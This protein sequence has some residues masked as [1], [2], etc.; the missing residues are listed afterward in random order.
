VF[1]EGDR[2][3]MGLEFGLKSIKKLK[4]LAKDGRAFRMAGE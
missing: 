2:K 4:L 1:G 3:V